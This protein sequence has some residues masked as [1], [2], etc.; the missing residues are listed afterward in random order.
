MV[1][2]LVLGS[3][4]MVA[5]A[6]RRC[7]VDS[8]RFHEDGFVDVCDGFGGGMQKERVLE[9]MKDS[10][11]GAYGAIGVALLLILKCTVLTAMATMLVVPALLLA[12][13]WSRLFA[14][15]LIWRLRYVREEGKAKPL[16]QAISDGEFAWA[17]LTVVAPTACA[18]WLR[19]TLAWLVLSG[20]LIA[21]FATWMLARMFVRRI[22]GYTGDCLGAVQQ[23]AEVGVYLG[24]ALLLR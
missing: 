10:R 2:M 16:A 8:G 17:V 9:I 13:A 1:R 4:S 15:A 23:V 14:L 18:L 7:A 6:G 24:F 20:L 5:A 21:S 22:G 11:V 12:H 19:P 3:G